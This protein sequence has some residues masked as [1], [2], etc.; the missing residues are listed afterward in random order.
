MSTQLSLFGPSADKNTFQSAVWGTLTFF[1]TKT[2]KWKDTCRRCLLWTGDRPGKEVSECLNAPCAA[3][4]RHDG[5]D[6]YYS[7]HDMPNS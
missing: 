2:N 1:P 6:G 5:K 3:C 7:I 4:E